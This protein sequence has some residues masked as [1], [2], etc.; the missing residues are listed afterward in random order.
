MYK[1]TNK[2]ITTTAASATRIEKSERDKKKNVVKLFLNLILFG[3]SK[4]SSRSSSVG[5]V[6]KGIDVSRYKLNKIEDM[7]MNIGELKN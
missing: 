3:K 1:N 4:T 5:A 6:D 7:I 2:V